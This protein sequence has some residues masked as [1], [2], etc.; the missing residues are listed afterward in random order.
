MAVE[1]KCITSGYYYA[2]LFLLEKIATKRKRYGQT[3][4][5]T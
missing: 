1:Y 4:I 3:L 5:G 2:K